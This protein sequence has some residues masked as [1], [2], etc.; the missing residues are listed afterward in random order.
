MTNIDTPDFDLALQNDADGSFHHA[1][2][3]HLSTSL[4]DLRAQLQR[5][6][7]PLDF[8]QAKKIEAALEKASEVIRF[9]AQPSLFR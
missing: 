7:S 3:T 2:Q 8:E 4:A 1:V 5:G 9:S 6:L